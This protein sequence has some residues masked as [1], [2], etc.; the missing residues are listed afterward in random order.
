VKSAT[1]RKYELK[2]RAE[3]QDETRRRIVEKVVELHEEV[4]PA[5][6]T[7]VEIA[8]RAGVGRPTVY[9]HFPDEHELFR[10][11]ARHW[12]GGNPR[13]EFAPWA[14]IADPEARLRKALGE[15]YAWYEASERML[16]NI[17]RDAALIPALHDVSVEISAEYYAGSV[18]VL[19]ADEPKQGSRQSRLRAALGHALEFETWRSLVRRQGLRQSEAVELMVALVGLWRKPV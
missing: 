12:G 8:K 6:T 9:A 7:V 5:H 18:D 4:G 10:A 19:A 13:P 11:C 16:S 2:R 17:R 1:K 3:R 14:T 15:L